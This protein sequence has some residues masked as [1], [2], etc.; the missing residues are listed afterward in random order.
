MIDAEAVMRSRRGLRPTQPNNFALET[1]DAFLE[2]WAS[3]SR[4]LAIALPGFARDVWSA[5]AVATRLVNW[6]VAASILQLRPEDPS[7]ALLH[8]QL[9]LA[10]LL[11]RHRQG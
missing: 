9:A 1:Q 3:I 8:R 11:P 7:A 5:R 2:F 6:A 4:F 10:D